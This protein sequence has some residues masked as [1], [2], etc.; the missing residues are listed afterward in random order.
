[1][2]QRR[3]GFLLGL[4]LKFQQQGDHKGTPLR[5]SHI[6]Y[7]RGSGLSP[8]L[9]ILISLKTKKTS[10]WQRRRGFLLGI[11]WCVPLWTMTCYDLKIDFTRRWCI[12]NPKKTDALTQTNLR[13]NYPNPYG[14]WHTK[15]SHRVHGSDTCTNFG[16]LSSK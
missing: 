16:I 12:N 10:L 3:G 7:G 14:F 9:L 15:I 5:C 8:P 2:W 11:G 4:K 6:V 1:M 13:Q